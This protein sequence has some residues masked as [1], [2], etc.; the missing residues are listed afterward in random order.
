MTEETGVTIPLSDEE[1][2]R[3]SRRGRRIVAV[4]VAFLTVWIGGFALIYARGSG[5][6]EAWAA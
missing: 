3:A 4:A 6:E 5:A 1:P 2:T